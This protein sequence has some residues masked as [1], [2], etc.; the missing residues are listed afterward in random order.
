MCP[1]RLGLAASRDA[2]GALLPRDPPGPAAMLRAQY[3]R[4][5]PFLHTTAALAALNS[6]AAP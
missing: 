4:M 5:P 1:H 2:R 6:D 3:E